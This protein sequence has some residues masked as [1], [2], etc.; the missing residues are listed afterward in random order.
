MSCGGGGGDD[1][2]DGGDGDDVTCREHAASK[3]GH[4]AA[5]P[6]TK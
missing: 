4:R 6:V 2:D 1:G 3:L 5:H